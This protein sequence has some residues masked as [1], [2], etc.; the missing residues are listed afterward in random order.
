MTT[1]PPDHAIE[2]DLARR[3]R[4]HGD[5]AAAEELLDR[6]EPIV[7]KLAGQFRNRESFADLAQLG[8]I[9]VL[10]SA[11]RFDPDRGATFVQFAWPRIRGAMVDALRQGSSLSGASRTVR[12][13][14]ELAHTRDALT[15]ELQRTPTRAE[16]ETRLGWSRRQLDAAF[17]LEGRTTPIPL[18]ATADDGSDGIT[19]GHTLV[20]Q[21]VT[22]Q[23]EHVVDTDH[24]DD[25][26]ALLWASATRGN[27]R[28]R[29]V[30]S[31]AAN[32]S[33]TSRTTSASSRRASPRCCATSR[34]S[35]GRRTRSSST[36][37]DLR[38]DGTGRCGPPG[39]R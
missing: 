15:E 24:T 19:L 25:V 33:E 37:A 10:E 32:T 26:H 21:D 5:P 20:Q 38:C 7:L 29:D 36:A 31:S 28:S 9:A 12:R 18:S 1:A 6:C 23:P 14:G 35:S 4:D 22:I 27:A 3:V 11:Q 34:R 2:G 39:S 13:V 16:L 30:S 8:R 17:A